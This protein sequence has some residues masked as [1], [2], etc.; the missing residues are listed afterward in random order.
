MIKKV[1]ETLKSQLTQG[2]SPEKL[3]QSL[4]AGFLIGCFPLLG[5]TTVLAAVI[6][7]IFRL[8]HIVVQTANYLMYPVQIILIPVYIEVISLLVDVGNVPI[9]PDLIIEAFRQ[10]RIAFIKAYAL[11]GLYSV[12]LWFVISSVLFFLLQKFF[13]PAIRK[14]SKPRG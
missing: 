2:A 11:V 7:M 12:V 8:N 10:D 3:A 6:G 4:S 1:Q 13:L 5:F 14:L 9:R